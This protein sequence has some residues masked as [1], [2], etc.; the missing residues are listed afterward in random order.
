MYT[1]QTTHFLT[2]LHIYTLYPTLVH[3]AIFSSY[4]LWHMLHTSL[5]SYTSISSVGCIQ[6][7]YTLHTQLIV[8]WMSLRLH[9]HLKWEL[10][11]MFVV[12]ILAQF[13]GHLE[14]ES[15]LWLR[16]KTHFKQV[17]YQREKQT[18]S[19]NPFH[20]KLWNEKVYQNLRWAGS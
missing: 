8:N 9:K 2:W 19:A 3:I 4:A 6:I 20:N 16:K 18:N 17:I 14:A 1:R 15:F 13:Q 5:P 11:A 7:H 12:E 10:P